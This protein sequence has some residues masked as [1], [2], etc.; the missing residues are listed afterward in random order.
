MFLLNFFY[1]L[2][3]FWPSAPT[4]WT[5]DLKSY[6]KI[7]LDKSFP[8]L[9]EQIMNKHVNLFYEVKKHVPTSLSLSL[10]QEIFVYFV[11][12]PTIQ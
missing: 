7:T 1:L 2:S 12:P 10:M 5:G 6:L 9:H 11:N 3:C 4:A 8:T